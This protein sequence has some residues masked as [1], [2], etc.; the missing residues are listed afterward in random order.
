MRKTKKLKMT[1]MID[2]DGK[3]ECALCKNKLAYKSGGLTR[4]LRAIHGIDIK[5]Y[6][7]DNV[8][9]DDS[10]NCQCGCGE[11]TGWQSRGG[12]YHDYVSGHN[13]RGKNKENDESVC[14][15]TKKMIKNENWKKSTF[16]KGNKPWNVGLTKKISDR[17]MKTWALSTMS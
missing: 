13:Y 10:T 16:N 14:R 8:G 15:R 2:K 3:I 11:I 5:N 17:V 12:Y 1:D 6:Y 9:G 7:I 4:H